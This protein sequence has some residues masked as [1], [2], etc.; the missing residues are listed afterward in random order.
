M[1]GCACSL[2]II[3]AKYTGDSLAM[4]EFRE[5]QT[6]SN[7]NKNPLNI[8]RNLFPLAAML[9]VS[10]C[11]GFIAWANFSLT[12]TETVVAAIVVFLV[13][14]IG[15]LMVWKMFTYA[16]LNE[17]IHILTLR[18]AENANGVERLSNEMQGLRKIAKTATQ[19]EIEPLARELEVI[20]SLIK[21][22]AENSADTEIRIADIQQ[23]LE[24]YEAG[25]R[26]NPAA[27]KSP[28]PAKAQASSQP[29]EIIDEDE[30]DMDD[31]LIEPVEPKVAKSKKRPK[32]KNKANHK[33]LLD[34][35]TP[36]MKAIHAAVDANNVDLYLQP[37]VTLPQ[38]KPKF[39]EALSRIRSD[40]GDLIRPAQYLPSAEQSGA[41]PILDKMLLV[42]AVQ[43][44]QRLLA[45]KSDATIVCNIAASSLADTNFFKD[46]HMLLKT[47]SDLAD[48][49][50]FEFHQETVSEFSAIEE[51]SIR[52]LKDLGFRFAIDN[53]TDITMDFQYLTELGFHFMKVSADVLLSAKQSGIKDIHAHDV[54][55]YLERNGIELIVDHIETENQVVELL[56]FDVKLGQGYLF[57]PPRE[58]KPDVTM[59]RTTKDT[60]EERLAS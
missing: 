39:Y 58:V 9:I 54:P 4:R 2:F 7:R 6:I 46:F 34:K 12:T 19:A 15:Y 53:V 57:A 8:T 50:V 28:K 31:W 10:L 21:Q 37:I 16:K 52:A 56:E 36:I 42:R 59:V 47:K 40:D 20:I 11:A 41:M 18:E 27:K 5:Q 48:H 30:E 45:R 35:D 29:L 38:R 13:Q 3:M 55:R 23:R 25:N 44:L 14:F 32:A 43:V 24:A 51:E 22:L 49:L 33:N 1:F 26:T 17:D 60:S